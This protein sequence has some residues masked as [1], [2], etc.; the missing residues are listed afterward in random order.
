MGKGMKKPSSGTIIVPVD[1]ATNIKLEVL[2][3]E[4]LETLYTA[5]CLTPVAERGGLKYN[6]SGQ[7]FD[8]Y[9]S[10]IAGLPASLRA[11]RV[12]APAA[13][14]ASG[15]LI[16]ADSSLCEEPGQRLSLSYAQAY[17]E[18]VEA[19]F[20]EIAGSEDGF[21]R[22]TGSVRDYPGSLTLLK[23]FVFEQIERPD[24]LERAD[25][26][27]AYGVLI[28]GHFLG[29]DYLAAVKMAGAEHS[30]W[31]C[32]SGARDVT[33]RPGMPSAAA[34][35]VEAFQR[36][37][38]A[39]PSV[40]Y[41][42]LGEVPRPQAEALGLTGRTLAVSGGHD[43][44]LS[45]L[46][47]NAVEAAPAGAIHLEAG[48][49]TMAALAGSSPD[50]PADGWRRGLIV[51]GTLDGGPVVTSMYG[52]GRD[53]RYLENMFGAGAF[54]A[55]DEDA[56]ALESVLRERRC[57]VLPGVASENR[58]SGPF[59]NLAGKIANLEA[60]ME[61]PA[62]AHAL[63][64]LCTALTA[65]IQIDMLKP[66][67][68]APVILTGGGSRDPHLGL[69]LA[70]LSGR[71]VFT[72]RDRHGAP[73]S[74]TTTLGAALNGKA[75]CLGVHPHEVRPEGLSLREIEP[76]PPPLA[77]AAAQYHETWNL[78]LRQAAG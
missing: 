3:F 10:V 25:G 63:A 32:H 19:A 38:T 52:G 31:M 68:D 42:P 60:F 40:A 75:A 71:R 11:C 21:F 54:Q 4:S 65:L 13:R 62:R 46:P 59:P 49:W 17:P 55:R 69:I 20:R 24:I 61:S 30:Y 5:S 70:T 53:F 27:A 74:E 67:S 36:L 58:G 41:I 29:P 34:L 48:S 14:G 12:I 43:T 78:E 16:G 22:Q 57:F 72:L 44:C 15:A 66:G 45:H 6:A 50:L 37:V 35:R 1:G 8:W 26:F 2:D 47:L 33:A 28:A 56:A 73:L 76:L 77:H 18:R 39:S 51:Q 7:Q 23:R 9:G 64:S